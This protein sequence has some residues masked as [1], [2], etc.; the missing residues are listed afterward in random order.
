MFKVCTDCRLQKSLAEFN[1]GQHICRLCAKIRNA[2]WFQRNKQHTNDRLSAF[3]HALRAEVLTH[4]GDG[5]LACMCCGESHHQFLSLDHTFGKNHQIYQALEHRATTPL[6]RELKR[7]GFPTGFRTLCFNCNSGTRDGACAHTVPYDASQRRL[8]VLSYY[9]GGVPQCQCCGENN[10]AF[11]NLDHTDGGGAR[12]WRTLKS[13]SFTEWVIHNNYPD[14]FRVLCSN[15]NQAISIFGSC[16]H[17]TS[18][19]E[20]V[21]GPKPVAVRGLAGEANPSAKLTRAKVGYI[22]HLR[23]Q[24]SSLGVLASTFDV[25]KRTI[26]QIVHNELWKEAA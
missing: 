12:H 7:R 1:S 17:G 18:L 3:R 6:Y 2:S 10:P 22:R 15:C 19:C 13:K 23:K 16:P 4:Y 11:L 5:K 14:V 20:I 9:S 21:H 24:G 26:A 25:S 8:T